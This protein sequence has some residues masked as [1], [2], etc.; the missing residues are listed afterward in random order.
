MDIKRSNR[1]EVSFGPEQASGWNCT[2]KAF[3]VQFHPEARS[4]PHDTEK[5]FGRFIAMME[6]NGYAAE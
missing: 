3:T 6:E 2:V 4:G 5:L 1:N